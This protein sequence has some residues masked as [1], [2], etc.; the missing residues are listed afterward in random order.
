MR[1]ALLRETESPAFAQLEQELL[2]GGEGDPC[3]GIAK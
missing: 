1:H 2:V 3:T